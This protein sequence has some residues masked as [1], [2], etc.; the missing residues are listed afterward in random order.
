MLPPYCYTSREFYE[1]E[2]QR[3]FLEEWLCVGRPEQAEKPG[4]YL[5]RANVADEP[6]VIARDETGEL[7]AMS[8]VCRHRAQVVAEGEGNV[9]LFPLSLPRLDLLAAKES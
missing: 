9:R 5:R 4:D 7:H 1:L 8:A 2:V 3:I 6:V